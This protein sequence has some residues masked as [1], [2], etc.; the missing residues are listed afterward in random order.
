MTMQALVVD[1]DPAIRSQ[2]SDILQ[3]MGHGC[4]LAT[5]QLEARQLLQSAKA[6]DY[7]LLDLEIPFEQHRMPRIQNGENLLQ[8]VLDHFGYLGSPVLIITGHGTGTAEIATRVMQA[9]AIDYVTKPLELTGPR[10]LDRAIESALTRRKS[11]RKQ[12]L[13]EATRLENHGIVPNQPASGKAF[14]GGPLL[15]YDSRAE[16]CGVKLITDQGAGLSL[17]I[18]RALARKTAMRTFVRLSAEQLAQEA[19]ALG[20]PPTVTSC[21]ARLRK[22]AQQRLLRERGILCGLLDVIGHDHQGYFLREWIRIE[23]A[24]TPART[25]RND[26]WNHRQHWFVNRLASGTHLPRTAIEKKFHVQKRTAQRD[27][28]ELRIQGI[29]EFVGTG[30]AGN[31]RLAGGE[32]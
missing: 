21:I 30:V 5:T 14:D 23:E 13:R 28:T 9:G 4:E 16:L 7:A 19:G 24:A 1:D 27:L 15:F 6:F 17:Q 29:I 18:L 12:I 10:T 31:Y 2:V 32:V 26:G 25:I 3:S 8:E 11:Q 20:G 22:S